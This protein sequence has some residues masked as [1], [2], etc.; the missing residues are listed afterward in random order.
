MQ[1]HENPQREREF[2]ILQETMKKM[3]LD[4]EG[5]QAENKRIHEENRRIQDENREN[6]LRRTQEAMRQMQ[7]TQRMQEENRKIQEENRKIQEEMRMEKEK[8]KMR[9]LAKMIEG[10]A[11]RRVEK[12][13]WLR[14][15]AE[16]NLEEGIPP[17]KYPTG[18]EFQAVRKRHQYQDGS[19]HLAITGV[20]GSGKSS[21]VNAFRGLR[22]KHQDAAK[23]GTSETT[24]EIGRYCDPVRPWIFWYDIPGAGTLKVPD[25]QYFNDQGLYIFDIIIIAVDIRFTKID[26]GLLFSCSRFG[27]PVFI[28]RSKADQHISNI[29]DDGRGDD[30]SDNDDDTIRTNALNKFTVETRQEFESILKT[31]GLPPQEVYIVS[32]GTLITLIKGIKPPANIID[33]VKLMRDVIDTANKRRSQN[34]TQHT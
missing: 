18:D 16:R 21:L 30:D 26:V 1:Q 31:A 23:T 32:K 2:Q 13:V 25:W 19:L 34:Q 15:E 22:D 7:E 3:Q 8:I 27:I 5:I 4:A 33:E 12:E 28:V 17:V 9:E 29:V 14:E 10:E 20:S 24:E 11:R 6:E